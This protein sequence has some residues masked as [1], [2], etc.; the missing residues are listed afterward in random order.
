MKTFRNL[1]VVLSCFSV[2]SLQAQFVIGIKG[3]TTR[4][5]EEYGDVDTPDGANIHVDGFQ[6]SA[7]AYYK[8]NKTFWFG[9]EPGW[10]ERGVACEPGFIIFNSDTKLRLNY[11]EMP[12]FAMAQIPLYKDKVVL[13]TKTGFGAAYVASAFRE[14]RDLNNIEPTVRSRLTFDNEGAMRRWDYGF[15]GG[16]ALSYTSGKHEI[17]LD[18][19]YYH[20]LPDVDAIFTS[21]NRTVNISL[22]Y[23]IHLPF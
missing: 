17:M 16:L 4:A 8:L 15:Y 21:R 18:G 1:L 6:L 2:I 22:G 12:V 20:G 19:N 3:G 5:W 10:V 13:R 14:V 11:V 9:A 7:M 23:L